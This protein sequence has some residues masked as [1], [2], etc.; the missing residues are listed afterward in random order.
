MR[1][2]RQSMTFLKHR[3]RL[4]IEW[5]GLIAAAVMVILAI[6]DWAGQFGWSIS[7]S[8]SLTAAGVALLAVIY[9]VLDEI[10]LSKLP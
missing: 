5:L 8:S 2:R 7:P 1:K 6:V 4:C 10:R 9:L 3:W